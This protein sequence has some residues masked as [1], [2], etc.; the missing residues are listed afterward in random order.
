MTDDPYERA[1]LF[2]CDGCEKS[3][4][5]DIERIFNEDVVRNPG[6]GGRWY[7]DELARWATFVV[8]FGLDDCRVVHYCPEC[9]KEKP[10]RDAL[11]K[12]WIN[13]SQ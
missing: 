8:K 12:K 4:D 5:E 6:K 7:K 10:Y 11:T 3:F 9:Q 1:L 2:C 13:H